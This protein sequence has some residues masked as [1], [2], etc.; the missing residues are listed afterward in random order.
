MAQPHTWDSFL[1][2]VGT[3]YMRKNHLFV[4]KNIIFFLYEC[5]RTLF[6]YFTLGLVANWNVLQ[7]TYTV[8][9]FTHSLFSLECETFPLTISLPKWVRSVEGKFMVAG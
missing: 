5:T 9:E 3:F 4:R 6:V 7:F 2:S 1:C 8:K